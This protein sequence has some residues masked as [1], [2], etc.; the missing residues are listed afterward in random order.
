MNPAI[1]ALII[2]AIT[3]VIMITEV[4]PPAVT[5]LMGCCAMAFCG[6]AKP[7]VVFGGFSNSNTLM[8]LSML[9]FAVALTSTGI[10]GVLTRKIM[11][12]TRGKISVF[13]PT[14]LAL[15]F[16]ASGFM[17]NSTA[18]VMLMPFF[19]GVLLSQPDK[20]R[21]RPQR[22]VFL[23]CAAVIN[24]G[25]F[26]LAGRPTNVLGSSLL[27]ELTGQTFSFFEFAPMALLL[28]A[29]DA[30]YFFLCTKK[31]TL[32]MYENN[33]V[34]AYA[35]EN[36][37]ALDASQEGQRPT[38][39]GIICLVLFLL[40]IAALLTEK[41]HGFNKSLVCMT[42]MALCLAFRCIS[43]RELAK[44]LPWGTILMFASIL[45]M[46]AALSESGVEDLIGSADLSFLGSTPSPVLLLF[47]CGLAV[48]ILTQFIS[49]TVVLQLMFAL[50]FPLTVNL[51]FSF[52][53]FAVM[54]TGCISALPALPT[55]NS[56]AMMSMDWGNYRMRDF[57]ALMAP[58]EL[59]HLVAL[60]AIIPLIYPF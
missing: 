46:T 44:K 19:M 56:V 43:G 34:S 58:L 26:S 8:V 7:S 17:R 28:V 51:G 4:I 12:L 5:A 52:V 45:G 15:M 39:K 23:A 3:I 27:E 6:V 54:I 42:A 38:R 21:Y 31:R 55:A 29:L 40:L 9:V 32:K 49:E 36:A 47:V 14:F 37:A 33:G 35:V 50:F 16:L 57:F 20:E 25:M 30:G 24:G 10:M 13:I 59:I 11:R 60:T 2:L 1:L 41:L 18:F 22:F 48:Y 53:P